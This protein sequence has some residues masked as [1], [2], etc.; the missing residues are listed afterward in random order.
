MLLIPKQL[1]NAILIDLTLIKPLKVT[2][3]LIQVVELFP[4]LN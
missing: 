3:A 2:L 4:L 1:N